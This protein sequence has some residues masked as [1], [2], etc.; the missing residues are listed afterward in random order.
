[1]NILVLRC[2]CHVRQQ[3]C[4]KCDK[5]LYYY[6]KITNEQKRTL[7]D[8]IS[9]LVAVATIGL[10]LQDLYRMAFVPEMKLSEFGRLRILA[11]KRIKAHEKLKQKK[12][13]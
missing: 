8:G 10:F 2:S 7:A 9:F 11:D 12:R 1:M 3:R 5:I 6:N 13:A 4:Q